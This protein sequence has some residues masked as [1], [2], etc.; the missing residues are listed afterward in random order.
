MSTDPSRWVTALRHSQDRLA[1]SVGGLDAAGVGAPSYDS[2]WS[3]AQV[4]SH[5]GSQAEIFGLLLEAGLSGG[6]APGQ[7]V[8]PTIWDAWNGRSPQAQVADSLRANEA[9]VRRLEG[10]DATQMDSFRL[11]A[12]GMDLDMTMFVRL[13]LG[14][15]AVHTWD[16]VVTLDQSAT[17]DHDAVELLVDGVGD[18]AARVGKPTEGSFTLHVTSTDPDRGFA[19]V[20]DGVLLEPWSEREA[21]GVLRLTSEELLRLVYGR[22]DPDHARSV[23]LDATGMTLDDVRAMFPGV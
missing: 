12:F 9:M 8:F 6:E 2:E 16:V 11:A 18:I 1:G 10:L 20:T 14:E 13:R 4:L 15:H 23:Q 19:L 22:L 17:V 3:V 21:A 5:L 7:D